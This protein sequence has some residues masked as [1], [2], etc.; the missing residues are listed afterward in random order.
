MRS[1]QLRPRLRPHRRIWTAALA[2][3]AA[4][5]VPV[6][7]GAGPTAYPNGFPSDPSF[8]PIGIWLQAPSRA[9]AY[10]AMGIN[11]FIGLWKG[12]TEAQLAELSRNGLFAVAAQNEVGLTSPRR[13]VIRA[14]MHQDEPDN[15]QKGF[16][17]L[18]IACVPAH[19]VASRSREMRMRDPTRPL[20]VNFGRAVADTDWHGRGICR[21]DTGYYAAASAGIDI[22]SFDIYPVANSDD[23]VRGR[24]E[25]VARGIANLRSWA[26]DASSFWAIIETTRIAHPTDRATPAQIRAQVWL[27]LTRGATGI[28]YFVHEWSDGFR[29]DG[30]F[31]HPDAVEAVTRINAEIRE[32]A[33]VLNAE[34]LHDAATAQDPAGLSVMAKRRDGSL[35]VFAAA[36]SPSASRHR[37]ALP[38]VTD[39]RAVALGEGRSVEIR[40]GVLEDRYDGYGVH[41][42]RIDGDHHA[43]QADHSAQ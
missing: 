38:G 43:A 39:A 28:G 18:H 26:R 14:W 30:I 19:E 2:A 35:Y 13:D 34:T 40:D 15:A 8:F 36:T 9:A 10:R 12:P 11:T 31:R 22:V 41:L 32:L 17:G 5:I 27:A 4:A 20:F 37:I 29:E 16:L 21:G 33:P 7:A 42:Y 1:R 3:L 24:L 23:P 25:Y 6:P